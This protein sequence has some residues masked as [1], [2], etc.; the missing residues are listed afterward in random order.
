MKYPKIDF[1]VPPIVCFVTSKTRY[2]EA[3]ARIYTRNLL[4]CDISNELAVIPFRRGIGDSL[5]N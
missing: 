3:I 4:N 5:F 1:V 2:F